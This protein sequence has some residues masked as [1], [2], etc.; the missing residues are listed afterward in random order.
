M[1]AA[2][3]AYPEINVV[4][5]LEAATVMKGADVA[6][7]MGR[8]E[9][10]M[11]IGIDDPPDMIES[12]RKGEVWG[13]FN[14]NFQKQGYESVR[15]IVDNFLGNPF[16]KYTDVGIVLINQDNIDDYISSM[17]EPV[18]LKGKPYPNL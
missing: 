13:S 15:N 4:M 10:I 12:I 8:L 5:F 2:L 14:Q 17:W 18:A 3:R 6:R 9:D 11:I 16:P 7:E 1:E